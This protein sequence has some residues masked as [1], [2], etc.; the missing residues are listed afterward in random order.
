MQHEAASEPTGQTLRYPGTSVFG[1]A[2]EGW[3]AGFLMEPGEQRAVSQSLE[4]EQSPWKYRVRFAGN[5][6]SHYG[7][8]GGATPWSRSAPQKR[9][10]QASVWSVGEDGVLT[11]GP[12]ATRVRLRVHTGREAPM[13]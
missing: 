2:R 11:A 8:V 13:Q 5:G 7:L 12:H 6:G 10:A 9:T 4:G 3:R 1:Q